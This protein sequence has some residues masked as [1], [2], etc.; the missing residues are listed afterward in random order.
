MHLCCRFITGNSI[1]IIINIIY[2]IFIVIIVIIAV[3]IIAVETFIHP[4]AGDVEV[5][6]NVFP[7]RK[8]FHCIV[9]IHIDQL[10]FD[11]LKECTVVMTLRVRRGGYLASSS[12]GW[13]PCFEKQLITHPLLTPPPPLKTPKIPQQTLDSGVAI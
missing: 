7:T 3:V 5:V 10:C 6:R 12:K 9:Q 1:I 11:T 2:I 8:S 4:D 13:A